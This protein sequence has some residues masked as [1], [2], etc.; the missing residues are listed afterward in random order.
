MQW[1]FLDSL[2]IFPNCNLQKCVLHKVT[3]W[4]ENGKNLEK[5]QIIIINNPWNIKKVFFAFHAF[6]WC[7]GFSV[8]RKRPIYLMHKKLEFGE[9]KKV[10]ATEIDRG[11][12]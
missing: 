11:C 10:V 2:V 6:E 5:A 12:K 9:R 4:E 3:Y 8:I 1:N 7:D